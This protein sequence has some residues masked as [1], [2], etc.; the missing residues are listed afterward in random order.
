[1]GV[2]LPLHVR[3]AAMAPGLRRIGSSK[4]PRIHALQACHM[5]ALQPDHAPPTL[6]LV[7]VAAD[8]AFPRVSE[9]TVGPE[10]GDW[11]ALRDPAGLELL[12]GLLGH[13]GP[14]HQ[15]LTGSP[16][17]SPLLLAGMRTSAQEA[18]GTGGQKL[19]LQRRRVFQLPLTPESLDFRPR[20]RRCERQTRW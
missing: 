6:I 17:S 7:L 4:H 3:P 2:R 5:L 16:P 12:I 9:D 19:V 14:S 8:C 15:L 20:L 11:H 18:P 13:V 10:L 1:V